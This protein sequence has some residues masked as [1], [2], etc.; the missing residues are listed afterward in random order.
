MVGRLDDE[1]RHVTLSRSP[2]EQE[3][4]LPDGRGFVVRVAVA[5][6]AYLTRRER[7]T[8]TLELL[9]D[10]RVEAT[11]NTVLTPDQVDEARKLVAEVATG[12]QSGNLEPT[13]S[14]IE[15]LADTLR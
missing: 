12:L 5:A 15:P 2:V 9:A 11:V 8:V 14:A 13:A 7:N 1:M 3:V 4:T 10:E 6:D